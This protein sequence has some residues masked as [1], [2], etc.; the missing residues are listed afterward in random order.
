MSTIPNLE[1]SLAEYATF[2]IT[3]FLPPGSQLNPK[4]RKN[5]ENEPYHYPKIA[6]LLPQ[7]NWE[8]FTGALSQSCKVIAHKMSHVADF[9]RQYFYETNFELL[10]SAVNNTQE[11]RST[12]SWF[13]PQTKDLYSFSHESIKFWSTWNFWKKVW[14]EGKITGNS[15]QT[16]VVKVAEYAP[17]IL[18]QKVEERFLK[19]NEERKVLTR[20]A[21]VILKD[22]D[23]GRIQYLE[24]IV[25]EFQQIAIE[26]RNA[27]IDLVLSKPGD[28][29]TPMTNVRNTLIK[30]IDSSFT[31]P[32]L[33]GLKQIYGV[34][35]LKVY[36]NKFFKRIDGIGDRVNLTCDKILLDPPQY[37]G[38]SEAD[39]LR[40]KLHY[41][42]VEEHELSK[43]VSH[44]LGV[45]YALTQQFEKERS[46]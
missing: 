11:I 25:K 22:K 13:F 46:I 8:R 42:A 34:D 24:K 9:A 10:Y 21:A 6:D 2:D 33:F 37:S 43:A 30:S 16:N 18:F 19:Y 26:Y 44:E 45:Y 7:T 27:T 23:Y 28:L 41:L 3:S 12:K 38:K 40:K 4:D 35:N 15:K 31:T 20:K 1:L 14:Y 36:L 39:L 29:P 17:R 5:P 32:D